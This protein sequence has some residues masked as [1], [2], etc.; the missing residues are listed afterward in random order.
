ML[1]LAYIKTQLSVLFVLKHEEMHK[2]AKEHMP[3]KGDTYK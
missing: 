3:L 2:T 1:W